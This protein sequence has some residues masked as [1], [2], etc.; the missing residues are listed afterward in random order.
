MADPHVISALTAKRAELSGEL[1]A[2]EKRVLQ[3][4]DDINSLDRTIRVFAPTSE[5]HTENDSM[6]TADPFRDRWFESGFLQRR[7]ACELD[8]RLRRPPPA[9]RD[10]ALSVPLR[11]SVTEGSNPAP[12]RREMVWGRRRG[13]GTIVAVAN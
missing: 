13:N 12:S 11:D 9:T 5:P 6:R 2:A 7:V 1:I 4:R 8:P 3:L 10:F